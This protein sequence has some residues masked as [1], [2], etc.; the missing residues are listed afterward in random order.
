[1]KFIAIVILILP[2][3]LNATQL[4]TWPACVEMVTKNNSELLSSQKKYESVEDLEGVARSGFLPAVSGTLSYDRGNTTTPT[5]SPNTRFGATLNGTE[6]IFNG[7]QDLGKMRQAQA[8]SKSNSAVV[9]T[10]K[11]KISFDLKNAYQGVMYAKEYE[12]F[13]GEIIRR[14]EANLNMVKLLFQSGRENKG[15][16]LLSQAYM[17]QARYEELQSRNA[18]RTAQTLLAKTLG[19]DQDFQ[20]DLQDLIPTTEPAGS[21]PDLR[22]LATVTPDFKKASADS[23]SAAAGITIARSQFFP[24][25]NVSG[26]AGR[27]GSEFWPNETDRWTVGVGLVFPLFNGGKDYYATRS[28]ADNWA[29]VEATRFNVNRD[30]LARLQQSYNNYVEAV[31]KLKVDE[32]FRKAAII[33][34][35]IARKRYNNGLMTF[36]DWDLVET[37]LIN[38]QRTYLQSKRDRIGAEAAWEQTQGKGVIP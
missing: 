30:L 31:A 28:A 20:Y 21:A 23:D 4:L 14:R 34:A 7:L 25:L 13:S 32:S 5:S 15:S 18:K 11:A 10:A 26:S 2:A 1:M 35:E 37:D 33:R 8:N 29:S 16:L 12:L 27:F 19:I 22:A 9:A 24:T 6:N 17:E 36:E 38:R 3:T